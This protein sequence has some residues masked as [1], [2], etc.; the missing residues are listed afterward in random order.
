MHSFEI[1][2]CNYNYIEILSFLSFIG[3]LFTIY[4]IAIQVQLYLN[5]YIEI[6]FKEENIITYVQ[7]FVY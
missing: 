5:K 6:L 3:I 4:F 1:F 2:K 7:N